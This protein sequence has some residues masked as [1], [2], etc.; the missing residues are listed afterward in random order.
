MSTVLASLRAG[1]LAG[2]CVI[3]GMGR[4]GPG[5]IAM[6]ALGRGRLACAAADLRFTSH[7]RGGGGFRSCGLG[8]GLAGAAGLARLGLPL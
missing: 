3:M 4:F 5:T 2:F 1:V 8:I 7:C 6:A